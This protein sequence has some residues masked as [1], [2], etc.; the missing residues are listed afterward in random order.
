M[1]TGSDQ[2]QGECESVIS[3]NCAQNS[4]ALFRHVGYR[5]ALCWCRIRIAYRVIELTNC[6]AAPLFG[7]VSPGCCTSF[8]G[9]QGLT[10]RSSIFLDHS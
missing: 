10:G 1:R 8:R 2:L 5:I 7:C 3:Q 4:D 6:L 9:I